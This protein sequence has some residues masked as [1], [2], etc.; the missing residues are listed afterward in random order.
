[1]LSQP[2][3]AW[4]GRSVLLAVHE[5]FAAALALIELDGI[6]RRIVLVPPGV[7]P[8]HLS[9]I[10]TI[11]EIDTI[12]TDQ[13]GTLPV[14]AGRSTVVACLPE[15]RM[16]AADPDRDQAT[17]WVLL[18]SG[19]TGMPKLVCHSLCSLAEPVLA[20][21]SGPD[22]I[23]ATFYDTR[24]YGGLQILLR[25]L[26][27][28]G[29]LLLAGADEPVG[30]FLRRAGGR[31]VTHISGT[32]S[33]WRRAMMMTE[34]AAISP[35]Y[36]RLSGEVADQG[37][38]DRLRM[39]YR[40]PIGHAFASTEAGVAFEVRDERAGFPASFLDDTSRGVDMK[41]QDD[42]LRIRSP[43]TALR[44]LGPA[45]KPLRDADGFVDTGDLIVPDGDRYMFAGRR[46]GV[47]NVGGQKV[48]PEEIEAVIN[49][50]P[51]V[52]MAMVSASRN[53]IIG[54]VIV[55][56]VMTDT[57][58]DGQEAIRARIQETCR[59]DLSPHKRPAL[60][61][62]VPALQIA[63]SGKLDRAHA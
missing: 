33:H 41:R 52:R 47:I 19:T 48:Y 60:I 25:G 46:D 62:F 54:S 42:T 2:S 38:L 9:A 55:A 7:A 37:T 26:L 32:P 50:V 18:T 56:R 53:R 30:D 61:H 43:R 34:A 15:P 21:P 49:A 12:V 4:R 20:N 3:D 51:G 59:R 58:A 31:A 40:T 8:D 36:V 22:S 13:P 10:V 39:F 44:Y 45:D 63:A 6:A 35:R 1:M 11:S 17:E 5:Q 23:W 24:R 57:D 28:G 16:K 14:E 29:S 27:G